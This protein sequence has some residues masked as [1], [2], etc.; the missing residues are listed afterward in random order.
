MLVGYGHSSC[1]V[2]ADGACVHGCFTLMQ[3]INTDLQM[4]GSNPLKEGNFSRN[5]MPK[6]L[7]RWPKYWYE[8]VQ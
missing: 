3:R 8:G 6:A 7:F 5:F 2:S 4:T 1:N